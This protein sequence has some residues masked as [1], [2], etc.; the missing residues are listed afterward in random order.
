MELVHQRFDGRRY[1]SHLVISEQGKIRAGNDGDGNVELRATKAVIVPL[2][3]HDVREDCGQNQYRVKRSFSD[4]QPPS[5]R[6][7]SHI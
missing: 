2:F 6:Q 3:R 1:D 7:E 5:K 4:A